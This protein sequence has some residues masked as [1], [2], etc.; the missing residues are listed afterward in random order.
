MSVAQRLMD[1]FKGYENAYGSYEKEEH[2]AGQDKVEIKASAF[3]KRAPV[4]LDLWERHVSGRS[5]LGIIPIDAQNCC[6][7]GCI[8]VDEYSVDLPTVARTVAKHHLIVCRSKSGGGHIF[9]FTKDAVPAAEMQSKLKEI[10]AALGYGGSEIFPKQVKMLVEKGDLGSWLNMPYFN[11]DKNG[12]YAYDPASGSKLPLED[13]L[14]LADKWKYSREAFK[15]LQLIKQDSEFRD[16]PPCLQYLAQLGFPDGMRNN[17]LFALAIYAKKKRPDAWK[18]LVEKW[19]RELMDPPLEVAEVHDVIERLEKKEYNYPCKQHPIVSHCNSGLCRTRKH[20]VGAGNAMP[21]LSSLRKLP[22]DQPIWFLDVDGMTAE[23][24]TDDLQKPSRFQKVIMEQLTL[25]MPTIKQSIWEGVLGG[26]MQDVSLMQVPEEVHIVGQFTELL[27][28]FVT[29]RAAA[30]IF[31]EITLNKPFTDFDEGRHYFKLSALDAYL[32][33]N[34]FT[35]YTRAKITTELR[36]MGGGHGFKQIKGK[37][38][39][40]WWIPLV[41]APPQHDTPKPAPSVI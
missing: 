31:D 7:W 8:D 4:T 39:N 32:K 17:G 19:N 18:D 13:F 20:G 30:K 16:G 11:A 41:V 10:S 40:Y 12:R 22:S 35:A 2:V 37:G 38:V 36:R 27:E 25:F 6:R 15:D 5:S 21:T 33:R 29:D 14:T 26:L 28:A 24:Q 1:L 9:L 23:F 3:T 34:Q